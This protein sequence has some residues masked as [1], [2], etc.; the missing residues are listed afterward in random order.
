MHQIK[1][2]LCCEVAFTEEESAA[3]GTTAEHTSTYCSPECAE[4]FTAELESSI[5]RSKALG[6]IDEHGNA[7]LPESSMFS[8]SGIESLLQQKYGIKRP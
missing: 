4:S 8:K 7:R 1:E 2:C 3:L 5:S 6:L